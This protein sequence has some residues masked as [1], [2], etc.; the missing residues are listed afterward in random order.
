LKTV[1]NGDIEAR[2]GDKED[3]A[4]AVE[5]FLEDQSAATAQAVQVVRAVQVVYGAAAVGT[6]VA[7]AAGT[8]A[9]RRGRLGRISVQ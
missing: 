2:L 8:V 1:P 3:G 7:V 4:E 9:V 6:V 5:V